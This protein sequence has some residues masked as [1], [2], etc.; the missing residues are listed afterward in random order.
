MKKKFFWQNGGL[1]LQ[2][3]LNER[4]VSTETVKIFTAEKLQNTTK[5]YDKSR[6]IGKKG[7]DTVYKGILKKGTKIVDEILLAK[8]AGDIEQ[9]KQVAKRCLRVKSD[10][11][12]TMKE[13]AIEARARGSKSETPTS[14]G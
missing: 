3:E 6:I 4:Q 8:R 12:P 1:L 9:I 14:M 7:F 10:E 5:N 2:Q 11:R 13:V